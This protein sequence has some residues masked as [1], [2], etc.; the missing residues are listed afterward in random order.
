MTLFSQIFLNYLA[1]LQLVY[2]RLRKV[3]RLLWAE[4]VSLKRRVEVLI[5]RPQ[6]VTLF[7]DRVCTEVIK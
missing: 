7:E 5:P 1:F 4:C 3:R 6:S 2:G